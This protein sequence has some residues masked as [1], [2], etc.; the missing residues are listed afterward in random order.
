[1]NDPQLIEDAYAYEVIEPCS[2]NGWQPCGDNDWACQQVMTS[3]MSWERKRR[4]W[5]Y[6]LDIARARLALSESA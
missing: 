3:N 4:M 2:V 5:E 6:R 1:M